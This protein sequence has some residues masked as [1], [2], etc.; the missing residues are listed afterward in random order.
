MRVLRGAV[1]GRGRA[2]PPPAQGAPVLPPVRR[3]RQEL[4]LR[5][6]LRAGGPLPHRAL[7]VRGGRVRGAAPHRRVPERN[8]PQRLSSYLLDDVAM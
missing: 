1:H 2:V 8:R 3:G 5:V 6:A 7:P 4:V